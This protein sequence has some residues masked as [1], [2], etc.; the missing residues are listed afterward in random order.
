M[1]STISSNTTLLAVDNIVTEDAETTG[2]AIPN[3]PILN[4]SFTD[5]L[6]MC[7]TKLSFTPGTQVQF[8][9]VS[10]PV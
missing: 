7:T 3:K 1:T 4:G 6:R 10:L 9:K 8:T 2:P 5:L